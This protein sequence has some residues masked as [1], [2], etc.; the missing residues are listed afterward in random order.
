MK[1]GYTREVDA[2]E[3]G[4]FP[5][6]GAVMQ[7]VAERNSEIDGGTTSFT[8]L[9]EG[10]EEVPI[11]DGNTMPF[12]R[13]LEYLRGVFL[14]GAFAIL[15]MREGGRVSQLPCFRHPV[16]LLEHMSL[17][18]ARPSW[19]LGKLCKAAEV[20]AAARSEW[21]LKRTLPLH[22]CIGSLED[23]LSTKLH[24]MGLGKRGMAAVEKAKVV[25]AAAA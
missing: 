10:G 2:L 17:D 1:A 3:Q 14:A 12:L 21:R 13:M 22:E 24:Q 9:L 8:A 16:F 6:L 15:G 25:A 20:D 19:F 7:K 23:R 18:P 5:G 11:K 4:I